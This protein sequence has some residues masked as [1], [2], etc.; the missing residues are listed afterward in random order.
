M[1]ECERKRQRQREREG[2][3]EEEEEE[4]RT[5]KE[6]KSERRKTYRSEEGVWER[7]KEAI[8]NF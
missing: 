6:G 1:C 7:E 3:E 5:R 8:Q 2:E 4:G